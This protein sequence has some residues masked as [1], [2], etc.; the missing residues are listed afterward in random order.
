[1]DE[2]ENFGMSQES[3]TDL[4]AMLRER[5]TPA[6]EPTAQAEQPTVEAPNTEAA[7]VI[8]PTAE[9]P[10]ATPEAKPF[11]EELPDLFKTEPTAT[12]E[13]AA[14]ADP[15]VQSELE[16]KVARLEALENHPLV[17]TIMKYGELKEFDLTKL[18]QA[19]NTTDYSKLDAKQLV[20]EKL[21]M[22]Y[23]SLTSEQ[24]EAEVDN[25]LAHKGIDESTSIVIKGEFEKGL[26]AELEAKKTTPEYIKALEEASK[27]IKPIDPQEQIAQVT[28]MFEA[29]KNELA[30]F[31]NQLKGQKIYGNEIGDEHVNKIIE[32]FGYMFN[33]T[34]TPYTT[35]DGKFDTKSFFLD[36]YKATNY[37]NDLKRAYELGKSEF[38]KERTNIDP[39]G[40]ATNVTPTNDNRSFADKVF[41]SI[42][43][44]KTN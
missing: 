22:E 25:Y 20:A 10:S 8:T 3:K 15:N 33:P 42:E 29:E 27:S 30:S 5:I 1:M 41:A 35:A 14:V 18:A 13:N 7:S 2:L 36:T 32:K 9:A 12:P 40:A 39:M 21:K 16:A 34:S 28:Q 37:D 31:V 44:N 6:A 4:T 38:V 43:K 19:Y 24:V 23:P 17:Q 11:F 26:R